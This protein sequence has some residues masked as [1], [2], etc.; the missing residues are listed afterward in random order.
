LDNPLSAPTLHLTPF[1]RGDNYPDTGGWS[2]TEGNWN[3]LQEDATTNE[4]IEA[5][6]SC[7]GLQDIVL[8]VV[9]PDYGNS[10]GQAKLVERKIPA[11][12]LQTTHGEQFVCSVFDLL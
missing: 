9:F 10:D 11:R 5:E 1:Q 6:L 4:C 3:L 8:Q 12:R 7:L 2:Q